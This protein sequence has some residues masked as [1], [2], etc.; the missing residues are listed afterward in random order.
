MKLRYQKII[1]LSFLV[2][3]FLIFGTAFAQGIVPQCDTGPLRGLGC[4]LCVF[5]KLV[6]NIIN[7]MLYVIFPLAVI[8]IVYGGF[9]IM[10]SAGSPERLKRGREIITTAVIGLAIALIAWLAV[11]TV[12]QVISGN[13]WQP[14]NSIECISR[15]PVV[16]TRPPITEPTTPTPT[17]GRTCPNCSTISN[18]LPIKTGSACA[19]SG[20]VTACQI[21][22]SLNERLLSL[23]QAIAADGSYSWQV[24]EAWP[25]TVTHKDQ[26]HYSGTC[27]DAGFTS[28]ARSGA[29]IKNFIGKS[30][31]SNLYSVYEV[32]TAARRQELINQGVPASQICTVSGISAEHFSVYMG[33]RTPCTR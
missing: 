10:V 8:F 9:M 4:D 30:A 24:T 19:L 23:N 13:S 25:P 31:N 11:S 6:E 15:E 32:Q 12:I 26:C 14:W 1:I 21:N 28:G 29:E 22:S 18:S 33:S 17:D 2:S 7:F 27:I 16:V 3:S 20:E 5:L